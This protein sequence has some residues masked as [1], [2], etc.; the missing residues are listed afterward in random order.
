MYKSNININIY[1]YTHIH[2]HTHYIYMYVRFYLLFHSTTQKVKGC[3]VV[4]TQEL[5]ELSA[6]MEMF[7]IC[8]V[9]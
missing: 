7:C 1:A 3:L 2:T 6:G 8:T 5:M 9:P 4:Y